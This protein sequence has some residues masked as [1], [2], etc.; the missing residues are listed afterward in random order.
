MSFFS[1]ECRLVVLFGERVRKWDLGECGVL[2]FVGE[3]REKRK[4]GRREGIR[5]GDG[6]SFSVRVL[7]ECEIVLMFIF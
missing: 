7:F 2:V 4:C 3:G 1:R 5:N 6:W